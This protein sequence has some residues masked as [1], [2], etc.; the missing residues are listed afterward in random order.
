MAEK[1][2]ESSRNR[3]RSSVFALTYADLLKVYGT[4]KQRRNKNKLVTSNKTNEE[5]Y[6]GMTYLT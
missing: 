3:F 4:R 6:I 1:K 2:G 5:N